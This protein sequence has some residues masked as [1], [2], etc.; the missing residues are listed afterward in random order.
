MLIF[1][2]R[3]AAYNKAFDLAEEAMDHIGKA[4]LAICDLYDCLET[5]Y[6][7]DQEE[8]QYEDDGK[9]S[10]E[11]YADIENVEVGEI[12]YKNKL[13]RG[14]RDEDSMD[15]A[16]MRGNMRRSMKGGMRRG[17]RRSMKRN[18]RYSY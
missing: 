17:M 18:G 15:R 7:A 9:Y 4:K 11:N 16:Y 10:E 14:L 1:E 2:F 12:N 5:C 6:E 8:D 13:R 3:E